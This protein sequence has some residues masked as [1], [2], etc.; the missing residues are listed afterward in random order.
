[1]ARLLKYWYER[2]SRI[3]L[4]N[5]LK[6]EGSNGWSWLD[7]YCQGDYEGGCQSCRESAEHDFPHIMVFVISVSSVNCLVQCN[8]KSC[9]MCDSCSEGRLFALPYCLLPFKLQ[10]SVVNCALQ[11]VV[12]Y[13]VSASI[14]DK[15]IKKGTNPNY[16]LN[17]H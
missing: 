2:C 4:T 11:Q 6:W 16:I 15:Q 8:E 9:N 13:S 3:W 5:N 10:Y 7:W 12:T 17:L 1:M 14:G